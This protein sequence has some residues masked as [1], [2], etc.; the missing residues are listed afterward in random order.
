MNMYEHLSN[1]NFLTSL[2]CITHQL[3]V[4][5]VL[6]CGGT[7]YTKTSKKSSLISN[8]TPKSQ[9]NFSEDNLPYISVRLISSDIKAII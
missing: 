6:S 5:A 8:L 4:E 2:M 9:N 1:N 3:A 7:V